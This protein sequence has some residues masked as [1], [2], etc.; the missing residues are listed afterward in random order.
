MT[1]AFYKDICSPANKL[2]DEEAQRRFITQTLADEQLQLQR[3]NP[4]QS[5]YLLLG[6]EVIKCINLTK[7][8]L[9]PD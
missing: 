7:L 3:E 4:K 8:Q 9:V 2:S 6:A 1:D 5:G